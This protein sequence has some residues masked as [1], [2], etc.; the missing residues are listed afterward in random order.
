V[1]L[2]QLPEF[3]PATLAATAMI[4]VITDERSQKSRSLAQFSVMF[5]FFPSRDF[6]SRSSKLEI[7]DAL[8]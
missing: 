3:D 6:A 1:R 5:R 4:G 7:L 8:W 2:N